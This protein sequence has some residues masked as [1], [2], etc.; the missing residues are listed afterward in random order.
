MSKKKVDIGDHIPSFRLKNQYGEWVSS[1]DLLG[2]PMV[3]YFYPKD[4]TPGCTAEACSFRDAYEEFQ[5][6]DVQVVG[7][8]KDD[9][10]THRQFAGKYRLPYLLLSDEDNELRHAFGVP[11]SLFGLLPGRVTYV[12][13][14]EGIVRHLFKSQLDIEGHI[15]K[16]KAFLQKELS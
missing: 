14:S 13:D 2:K 5:D 3:L 15:E 7:V 12:I 16:A 6:L 4:D 11:G 1:E 10:V 9:P 8:S